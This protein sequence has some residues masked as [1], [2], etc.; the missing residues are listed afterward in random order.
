[1]DKMF[2]C[3]IKWNRFFSMIMV[4]KEIKIIC[5][6]NFVFFVDICKYLEF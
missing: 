3:E 6:V 5:L 2:C 4:D 1:M